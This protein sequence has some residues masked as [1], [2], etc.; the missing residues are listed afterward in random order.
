[1]KRVWKHLIGSLILGGGLALS[2]IVPSAQA[3][4]INITCGSGGPVTDFCLKT[5]NEWADK[6]GH[7]VVQFT[8]PNSSSAQLGLFQQMFAAKSGDVDVVSID[9]VWPGLLYKHF[10]DLREH[11]PE[12]F[13]KQFFPSII[14]N[15]TAPDG[16]LVA[17]PRFT[18]A[19]LLYYRKD[20][21]EKH[22]HQPPETWDDLKRIAEDIL[23]K[24]GNTDLMGFVWQG[25]PYEGLTCDALEWIDS[26]GGGSIVEPDGTISVNNPNAVKALETA[27]SWVGTITPESILNYQE[28]DAR[29]AFQSGNAIFMRNWPYAWALGN[30][31][32]SLVKGKV[33]TQPLP[34]GT[35]EG[36]KNSGT[37]GGWNFAINKYSKHHKESA[38]LI[39][40]MTS[41]EV[42]LRQAI[43]VSLL[44]TIDAVYSE[45]EMIEKQ[46]FLVSLQETFRNS[47]ARPASI[48]GKKYNRVSNKFW[49]AAYAV[50]SGKE[51]AQDALADLEK[52]LTRIKGRKW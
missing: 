22:G 13:I 44:P 12:D 43:E 1:M 4:E 10:V 6:T 20:L 8:T 46:P 25:K 45:P 5:A 17:I 14:Q 24:E 23:A 52:E 51:T 36:S 28:E 26:F 42:Q 11:F 7:T 33:G 18:D 27:A 47:V 48:T 19:G 2:S 50:I 32:G 30:Q 3:V 41:A 35:T 15:N 49:N 31:E 39:R 16:R 40:Y 21:L 34:K 37:L 38:D 9:V 29:G